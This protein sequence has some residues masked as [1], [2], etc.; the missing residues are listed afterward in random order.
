MHCICLR[1]MRKLLN[2]WKNGFGNIRKLNFQKVLLLEERIIK[3]ND[4]HFWPWEI[5]RKPRS[6]KDLIHWKATEF[7][8]FLLYVSPWLNDILSKNMFFNL[9]LL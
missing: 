7:R 8:S 3:I 4:G 1:V 2:I 6:L 5:A 9:M